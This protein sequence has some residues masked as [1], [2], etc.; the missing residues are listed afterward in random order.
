MFADLLAGQK[1]VQ[2]LRQRGIVARSAFAVRASIVVALGGL[3][4]G[5]AGVAHIRIQ[6][7]T[8][9]QNV[10]ALAKEI[11]EPFLVAV[12]VLAISTVFFG[13]VSTVLQTR[14]AG[15]FRVLSQSRGDSSR[16]AAI[17]VLLQLFLVGLIAV[18]GC[19]Y[20]ME[21]ALYTLRVE[22]GPQVAVH[23]EKIASKICKVVVV[24]AAVL[25]ILAVFVYRVAFLIRHRKSARHR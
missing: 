1:Q 5:F 10:G 21:E 18:I 17:S 6:P 12:V 2:L 13:V 23:F 24:A 9:P 20:V 22:P 15:G 16:N 11:G 7:L 14:M 4:L 19:Q 25:A 3:F 8:E